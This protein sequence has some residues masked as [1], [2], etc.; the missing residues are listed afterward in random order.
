MKKRLIGLL[1]A[2]VFILSSLPATAEE[3]GTEDLSAWEENRK[4]YKEK[5]AEFFEHRKELPN[6]YKAR[7][8]N[9]KYRQKARKF[10]G[11]QEGIYNSETTENDNNTKN[12]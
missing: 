6:E 5:R 2:S 4:E 3:D 7:I 1:I 11:R 8:G 12:K 10:Y 9:N